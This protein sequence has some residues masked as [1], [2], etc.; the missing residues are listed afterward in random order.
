MTSATS[1]KPEEVTPVTPTT[2][3]PDATKKDEAS[4]T[5]PAAD[6]KK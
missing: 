3:T 5:P 4:K 6:A 2:A 1:P